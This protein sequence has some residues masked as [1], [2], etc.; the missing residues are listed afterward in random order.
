MLI[1]CIVGSSDSSDSVV[2][3]PYAL[4][5]AKSLEAVHGRV[6]R[7][8]CQV[9]L[10]PHLPT[11]QVVDGAN[12]QYVLKEGRLPMLDGF[13]FQMEPKIGTAVCRTART[14]V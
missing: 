10:L 2:I 5:S 6:G 3:F 1:D 11:L 4:Y 14:V 8:V 13:V 9:G 12:I 7:Q